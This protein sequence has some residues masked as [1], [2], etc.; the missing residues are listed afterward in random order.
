MRPGCIP[1]PGAQYA[2]AGA[3]WGAGLV[4]YLE[5]MALR[6]LTLASVCKGWVIMD[7]RFGLMALGSSC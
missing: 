2:E 7:S 5:R 6:P 4:W 1:W 3:S